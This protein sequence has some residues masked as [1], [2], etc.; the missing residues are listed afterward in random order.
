MELWEVELCLLYVIKQRITEYEVRRKAE[1]L[2][3]IL[4]GEAMILLIMHIAL[5][6]L[7]IAN[8][9]IVKEKMQKFTWSAMALCW[10]IMSVSE[11]ATMM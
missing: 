6:I 3:K 10:F 5:V 1:F 4:G 7:S 2:A 11:I 8:A 9:V